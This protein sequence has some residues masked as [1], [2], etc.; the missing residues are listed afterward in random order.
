MNEHL[1]EQ[2]ETPAL[3]NI[4]DAVKPGGQDSLQ[5]HTHFDFTAVERDRECGDAPPGN[6]TS[7]SAPG[8]L[9]GVCM[10]SRCRDKRAT[11][12]SRCYCANGPCAVFAT[13]K[14]PFELDQ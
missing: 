9:E 4:W 10:N 14:M 7:L 2:L 3:A 5:R 8:A 11:I 1:L 13:L 6:D 12:E